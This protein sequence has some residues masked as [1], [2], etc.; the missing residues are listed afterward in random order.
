MKQKKERP[1]RLPRT[2]RPP[3]S[4]RAPKSSMS[5]GK[6][7]LLAVVLILIAVCIAVFAVVTLVNRSRVNTLVAQQN[8]VAS[9]LLELGSYEDGRS[10][11]TQSE[12]K[13]SND[14]SRTLI[15]LAAGFSADYDEAITLADGYLSD[16]GYGLLSEVRDAAV[17]AKERSTPA[18]GSVDSYLT[19]VEVTLDDETRDDL[20]S[21]LLKVQNEINVKKTS[22]A[23]LAM[24]EMLTAGSIQTVSDE[25]L[26]KDSSLLS[27]KVQMLSSIRSGEYDNAYRAAEQLLSADNSFENRAALAN[28]AATGYVQLDKT[29]DT[30]AGAQQETISNLYSELYQVQEQ[31]YNATEERELKTLSE[32][33]QKIEQEISDTQAAMLREPVRR[34]INFIETTTP[35]S[36]R[37]TAAYAIELSQLYFR[38]GDEDTASELLREQLTDTSNGN[39]VS[40]AAEPVTAN[41]T[42]LVENYRE[43][44]GYGQSEARRTI[45]DRIADLLGILETGGY[46]YG[47]TYSDDSYYDF[48]LE[49]LARVYRGLN[50]RS[51]DASAY[52]TVRVTV[53]VSSDDGEALNMKKSD[54]TVLDMGNPVSVRIVDA[55]DLETD[56]EMSVILVIDRSGSM[57]GTAMEDTKNAV[58]NFIRN[59]DDGL[60]LGVVAFDSS[61][62]LLSPLGTGRTEMLR[63]VNAIE[64]GGGTDIQS[65]LSTACEALS[66]GTGRRTVILLSDG[67]DGNP[68]AIDAVLETLRAQNVCVYSIGFGGA[69][70]DYLAHI[71]ESTGGRF[72]SADN[73]ALLSDIYSSI[74]ETMVNDYV[75]EFEAETEPDIF[76]RNLH[77]ET[78]TTGSVTDGDYNVGV[79]YEEILAEAER[80]PAYDSYR[81]TGGSAYSK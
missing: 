45:W 14:I 18:E 73:S 58:I 49:V 32:Q 4:V 42:F 78:N 63:A 19:G 66:H 2:A 51:I 22:A 27:K 9:K 53:N 72:L 36:D 71:A 26:E 31:Y 54:F 7:R 41:L 46:N 15:V 24:Q 65:G 77:I 34:A 70:S 40:S 79:S 64:A 12:Q 59:A 29:A 75:L 43:A 1:A 56:E 67:S 21:I 55:K 38:A 25:E 33:M 10:L 62:E 48:V 37:N 60:S 30:S 13:K 8:Y 81:Q 20:L 76:A 80:V 3:K 44:S 5:K 23:I 57:G 6:K 28:L 52:P 50:I 69:D 17:A 11:A 74:G 35:L 47:Y 39:A 61:A 68:A 16:R